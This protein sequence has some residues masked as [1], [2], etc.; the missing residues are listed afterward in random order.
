MILFPKYSA[1]AVQAGSFY[2]LPPCGPLSQ[3]YS[4]YRHS[5][6]SGDHEIDLLFEIQYEVYQ[7]VAHVGCFPLLCRIVYSFRFTL[8]ML[9]L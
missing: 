6:F 8:Y 4:C 3:C 2:F 5:E 9:N 1:K 7:S